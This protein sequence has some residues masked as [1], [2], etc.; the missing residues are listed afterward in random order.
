MP[1]RKCQQD[2]GTSSS[3]LQETQISRDALLDVKSAQSDSSALFFPGE[4][5]TSSRGAGVVAHSFT[6]LE[7]DAPG[8]DDA[9]VSPIRC[10]NMIDV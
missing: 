7:C 5:T 6:V 4:A 9:S 3:H 8:H 2:S 1:P 10:M